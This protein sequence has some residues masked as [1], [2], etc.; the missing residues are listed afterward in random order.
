[1]ELF[2]KFIEGLLDRMNPFPVKNSVIVMDNCR[3]H[4]D[5]AIIDMIH[6]W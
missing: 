1:M 2:T 5:S 4:K 6:Q 3:I